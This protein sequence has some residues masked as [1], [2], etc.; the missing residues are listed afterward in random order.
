MSV[1]VI[2]IPP[3]VRLGARAADGAEASA[4]TPGEGYGYVLSADGL[5]VSS[6][7]RA[8]LSLLPRADSVVAVLAG[9]LAVDALSEAAKTP[10]RQEPLH[11]TPPAAAA[12]SRRSAVWPVHGSASLGRCT[13]GSPHAA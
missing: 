5:Q 9:R 2:L 11:A 12:Q 10:P 7:G 1:L 13:L 3:R 8:Q 6:H 4:S